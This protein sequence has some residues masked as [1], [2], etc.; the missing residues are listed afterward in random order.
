MASRLQTV[1]KFVPWTLRAPLISAYVKRTR[2]RTARQPVEE[3]FAEIYRRDSWGRNSGNG[4]GYFS[5]PGSSE[6]AAAPYVGLV[7]RLVEE[8]SVKRI[9]DVGCGDFQVGAELRF[10]GVTYIGVD[11]VPALINRNQKL[12]SEPD[13]QFERVNVIEEA[14]PRGDL[15]LVRQVFQHL[16]NEQITS[17]LKNLDGFPRMVVTEHLPAPERWHAANL[18][19]PHG[20]DIRVFDGSAVIL[21][22]PPFSMRSVRKV[23]EVT[24]PREECLI[25]RG[26]TIASFLIEQ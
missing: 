15:C 12:Y 9:V 18:D 13:I 14:P 17:A 11:I 21:D 1:S 22:Q 3:V 23:L 19:K 24:V 26:E 2:R 10:P 4:D 20:P 25:A 6:A 7:R 16:S 5:G 8:H